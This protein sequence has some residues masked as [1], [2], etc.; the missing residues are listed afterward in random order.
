MLRVDR[1][2]P[3]SIGFSMQHEPSSEA[4]SEERIPTEDSGE[5]KDSAE[6]APEGAGVAEGDSPSVSGEEEEQ[7]EPT[8]EEQLVEWRER[9]IRSAADLENYR[10]RTEREKAEARRYSNQVLLEELL[11]VVDNFQMGL[12]AAAADKDSMIY[13]G[14]EMVKKQ[15]DDFLAGQ[16]V[17]EV[18]AEGEQFDPSLHEAV[19][20]EEC[21]GSDE[22]AV[23]RVIRRGYR[24]H[25][26]LLRP[27][28][29]VVAKSPEEVSEEGLA[30]A[31]GEENE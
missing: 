20:Q 5:I 18:A 28:N 11:P 23:L 29:V 26:R 9:A 13:R 6:S 3:V 25:D 12:Q 17:E 8:V 16:G 15:L 19:S 2:V 10:K 7:A 14:M 21:G 31:V 24:M 27:A 30:P 22:G 1:R 4:E